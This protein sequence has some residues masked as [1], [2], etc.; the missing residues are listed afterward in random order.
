MD[1]ARRLTRMTS[2]SPRTRTTD[3]CPSAWPGTPTATS[4]RSGTGTPRPRTSSCI[5]TPGVTRWVLSASD[6][7][8]RVMLMWCCSVLD[9]SYQTSVNAIRAVVSVICWSQSA[10]ASWED[11]KTVKCWATRLSPLVVVNE[12]IAEAHKNKKTAAI[13]LTVIVLSMYYITQAQSRPSPNYGHHQI[14]S[15]TFCFYLTQMVSG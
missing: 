11:M 7:N 3:T 15:W 5:S 9:A 14:S 12:I 6:K 13:L 2:W 4:A 1:Q 8:V 10:I